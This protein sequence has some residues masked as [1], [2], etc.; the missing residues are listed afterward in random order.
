VETA[1]RL[2]VLTSGAA[3]WPL[4]LSQAG[5]GLGENL[6]VLARPGHDVHLKKATEHAVA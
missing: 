1:Y 5:L 3:L 4:R 2:S 6:C